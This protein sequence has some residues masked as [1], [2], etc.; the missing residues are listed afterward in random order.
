[1]SRRLFSNVLYPNI[2]VTNTVWKK[3]NSIIRD[4]KKTTNKETIVKGFFLSASVD[5]NNKNTYSLSNLNEK[6]YDLIIARNN[7]QTV[8]VNIIT[9]RG[10]DTDNDIDIILD[11]CSEPVLLGTIIDYNLINSSKE[12]AHPQ[13]DFIFT[14]CKY[15]SVNLG[16][17][18]TFLVEKGH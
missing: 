12:N 1:M 7:N 9:H 10:T 16:K 4:S 11:P 13:G 3:L 14:P 6:E 17:N 8:P 2:T 18:V 5:T 15:A